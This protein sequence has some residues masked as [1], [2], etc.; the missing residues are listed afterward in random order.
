MLF[1]ERGKKLGI[2]A[3]DSAALSSCTSCRKVAYTTLR[4]GFVWISLVGGMGPSLL[5]RDVAGGVIGIKPSLIFP[6]RT[7]PHRRTAW[8]A[9]SNQASQHHALFRQQLG[10]GLRGCSQ[11]WYVVANTEGRQT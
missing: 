1:R 10:R 4:W 3:S 9:H 6:T 8:P 2:A 5:S 7:T 11:D